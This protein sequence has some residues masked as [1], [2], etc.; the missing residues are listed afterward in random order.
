MERWHAIAFALIHVQDREEML[1]T[2]WK[3][4]CANNKIATKSSVKY[5]LGRWIFAIVHPSSAS[6]IQ[7]EVCLAFCW[8]DYVDRIAIN[9]G[10]AE[11]QYFVVV[12][13]GIMGEGQQ[14]M[15]TG[16]QFPQVCTVLVYQSSI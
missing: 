2:T 15:K 1:F 8:L 14:R 7:K 6:C 12:G 4:V 16:Q 5:T 3:L 9:I 10:L 11:F 13:V